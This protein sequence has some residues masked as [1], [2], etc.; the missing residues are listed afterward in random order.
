MS[1]WLLTLTAV[2]MLTACVSGAPPTRAL[3]LIRPP[4]TP[5][6]HLRVLCPTALPDPRSG[7]LPD[8]L[9]NH[10]E[11][12]Q[13]YHLCRERHSGLVHWLERSSDELAD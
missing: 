6:A 13:L 12:A 3:S 2:W 4:P 9:A 7:Q 5:P 8:L 11:S 10:V 1:R